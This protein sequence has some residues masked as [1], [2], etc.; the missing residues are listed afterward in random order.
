MKQFIDLAYQTYPKALH[1]LTPMWR[2]LNR[3]SG[4]SSTGFCYIAAEAAFHTIGQDYT[5]HVASYEKNGLRCTHW[6]LQKR[7]KIIDPTA[8]QYLIIGEKPPYCL[9]RGTGFLTKQPSKR[10]REFLNL[11]GLKWTNHNK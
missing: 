11:M 9:G 4:E 5:P 2:E 7:T 3:K 1:L 6:W 8:R 10:T